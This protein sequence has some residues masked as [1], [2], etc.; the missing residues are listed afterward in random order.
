MR[1]VMAR[2]FGGP[3]TFVIETAEVPSVG[4]GEVRV[5]IRAV[6]ISFVDSLIAR[7]EYQVRP[8]IPFTP[9]SEFA[10][11]ILAVGPGVADWATGDRVCGSRLTGALSEEAVVPA[12]TLWRL[13]PGMDLDEAAIF[14]VSYATAY[15][16]LIQRGGLKAGETVLVLGASGAVGGAAVQIATALGARVIAAVSPA[17]ASAALEDGAVAIVDPALGDWRQTL[18]ALAP[19]G[20]DIV[21]DPIGG[22]TTEQAFRSLAWNGRHMVIGFASGERPSLPVH[23]S[24]LKGAAL[25]GV[26]IRTFGDKE[27]ATRKANYEALS[28]LQ[29]N[30]KLRPRIAGRFAF[31]AFREAFEAS[32][33]RGASGRIVVTLG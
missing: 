20:V 8:T 21:V 12:S 9:G 30:G 17:K 7:G 22:A 16:A 2:A 15:H 31:E 1:A 25:V 18:K 24:L 4:P 11:T 32:T 33:A 28:A 14:Q 19:T 13:P 26:D 27:P 29:A 3:E 10:G 6:G 23:L 5:A